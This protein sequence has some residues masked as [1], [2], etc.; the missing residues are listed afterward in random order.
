VG[1]VTAYVPPTRIVFTWKAPE[2][3]APTEVEVRFSPEQDGTRV[4][5][6]HRGWERTGARGRDRRDGSRASG[7]TRGRRDSPAPCSLTS[8]DQRLGDA[9]ED[10]G[11]HPEHQQP[12]DGLE[13][14]EQL[15]GR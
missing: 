2:W 7:R 10:R 11:R 9:E 4:D 3:D 12:G 14:P 8:S 1:L 5:L 15:P 6:E 13:R